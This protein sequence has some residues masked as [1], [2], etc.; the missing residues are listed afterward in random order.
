[1][2]AHLGIG[3][4]MGTRIVMWSGPRN[5]STAMMRAFENR[6]DCVVSDEPFYACYLAR[7]GIDHPM[8]EDI[9]ETMEADYDRIAAR[10]SGP[11]PDGAALWYQKHM[12]H[13]M[14]DGDS[15]DWARDAVNCFLIRDPFRVVASYARKRE[16]PTL[17]DIG[18]ARE[19]ALFRETIASTGIAPP[20]L[21]ADDVLRDPE[22]ALRALASASGIAF[23]P[24]MLSW[25]AGRRDS[26]GVWADH[27]YAAVERS[28]GFQPPS[29]PTV[30]DLS[31]NDRAVA[32]AAMEDYRFLLDHRLQL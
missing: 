1:M 8:R 26:D 22:G 14:L 25:P 29:E 2:P 20:V 18:L 5:I 7:T 17:D 28:T 16:N 21:E 23:D 10:L 13:H 4:I 9:L 24:A 3:L 12:T 30:H 11:N 15:L 27:W 19:A 32:E 31:D 6:P